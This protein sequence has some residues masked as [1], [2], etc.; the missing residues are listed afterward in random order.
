M[1]SIIT[2]FSPYSQIILRPFT[3]LPYIFRSFFSL[4]VAKQA[5]KTASH[6]KAEKTGWAAIELKSRTIINIV[7]QEL[8]RELKNLFF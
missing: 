6:P 7:C 8:I 5:A 2:L 4:V 1:V 3:T